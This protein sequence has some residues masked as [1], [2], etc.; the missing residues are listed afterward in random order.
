MV[1]ENKY[2]CDECRKKH[3]NALKKAK[4]KAKKPPPKNEYVY[5]KYYYEIDEEYQKKYDEKDPLINEKEFWR[6]EY[7]DLK[8]DKKFEDYTTKDLAALFFIGHKL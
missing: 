8:R 5:P 6:K 3:K 1:E 7:W 2:C 4:A